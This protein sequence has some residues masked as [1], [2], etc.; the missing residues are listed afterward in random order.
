MQID[1]VDGFGGRS[2][3][4]YAALT[5]KAVA[6]KE[7]KYSERPSTTTTAVMENILGRDCCYLLLL[8]RRRGLPPYQRTD[9]E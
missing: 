4:L 5:S 9:A 1:T 6:G 7:R 8:L 3:E 2:A